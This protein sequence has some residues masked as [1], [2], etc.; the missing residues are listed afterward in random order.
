MP[1]QINALSDYIRLTATGAPTFTNYSIVFWE[2]VVTDNAGTNRMSY[3]LTNSSYATI[4]AIKRASDNVDRLF[5][6]ATT[7]NLSA[8]ASNSAWV[9][10][11]L[12]CSGTGGSDLKLYAWD[13]G[14]AD[15]AYKSA[16]LTGVGTATID[17]WVLGSNT[18]FSEYRRARY[19]YIK[20]WDAALSLAELQAERAQGKPVRTSNVNRYH[21]LLTTSD[22]TDYSGNGRTVSFNGGMTTDGTEPVAWETASTGAAHHYYRAMLAR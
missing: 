11:A 12:T 9:M 19:A 21:R 16:T 1:V 22:T 20:V 4:H 7:A 13:A 8:N 2:Q 5:N 14:D 18:G 15:G 10:W 17:A 6:D 3:I